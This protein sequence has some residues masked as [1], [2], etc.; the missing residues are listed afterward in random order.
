M[1]SGIYVLQ[2]SF[3]IKAPNLY[4]KEK[5]SSSCR[6]RDTKEEHR[7]AVRGGFKSQF[8]Q[9]NYVIFAK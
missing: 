3:A 8:Y 5:K 2:P 7:F 6:E 4:K 1:R 9:Q